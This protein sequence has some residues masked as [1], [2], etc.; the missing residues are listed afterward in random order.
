MRGLIETH[1][2]PLDDIIGDFLTARD[3]KIGAITVDVK[4]GLD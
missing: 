1:R 2:H 3:P 4:L